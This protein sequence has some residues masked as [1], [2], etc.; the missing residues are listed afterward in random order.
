MP[1][2]LTLGG[3]L[4]HLAVKAED[5][6]ARSETG[7]G[8]WGVRPVRTHLRMIGDYCS[9][10]GLLVVACTACTASAQLFCPR[11]GSPHRAFLVPGRD[12]GSGREQ[13]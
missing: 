12:R 3:V 10:N 1:E 11:P 8:V 13:G 7:I 4:P 5:L 9:W 6:P 2:H